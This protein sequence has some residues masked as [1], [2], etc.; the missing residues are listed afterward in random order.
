MARKSSRAHTHPDAAAASAVAPA[1]KP[2]SA[3]MLQ[4]ALALAPPCA[5]APVPTAAT[6]RPPASALTPDALAARRA[7]AAAKARRRRQEES[8]EQAADR[9]AK[10]AARAR[11]RRAAAGKM[12]EEK[13]RALAAAAR[14]RREM[15]T[16]EETEARRARDRARAQERRANAKKAVEMVDAETFGTGRVGGAAVKG[17]KGS[18]RG[19]VRKGAGR[20]IGSGTKKVAVVGAAVVGTPAGGEGMA[21]AHAF[22]AGP[23]SNKGREGTFAGSMAY[24]DAAGTAEQAPVFSGGM[25][26]DDQ[27][28][29]HRQHQHELQHRPPTVTPG[30]AVSQLS[31][32]AR[33]GCSPHQPSQVG[34]AAGVASTVTPVVYMSAPDALSKRALGWRARAAELALQKRRDQTEGSSMVA[35]SRLAPAS[36]ARETSAPSTGQV[37]VHVAGA[38]YLAVPPPMMVPVSHSLA[39]GPPLVR[40]TAA[41]RRKRPL[42]QAEYAASDAADGRVDPAHEALGPATA[43]T[44]AK[45][46]GVVHDEAAAAAGNKD[47]DVGATE[48][49]AAFFASSTVDYEPV[50]KRKRRKK[51]MRVQDPQVALGLAT[52]H[53]V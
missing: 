38:P 43:A 4:P 10:N 16:Q 39:A 35:S 21:K 12:P 25:G 48:T 36:A 18:G 28:L 26:L 7:V 27:L 46:R 11:E 32:D 17:G 42:S 34:I 15:E 13:R 6:T 31:A 19:G 45:R 50:P 5:A 3:P 41:K 51:N 33:A 2:A 52:E 44:P 40:E 23:S 37:N 9:R 47:A 8:A 49:A 1:P 29:Q 14:R 53:D 30:I 20:P 24:T 22:V